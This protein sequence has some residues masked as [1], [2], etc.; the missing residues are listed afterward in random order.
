MPWRANTNK[1]VNY[2]SHK[3]AAHRPQAGPKT[4]SLR[5]RPTPSAPDPSFG[6]IGTVRTRTTRR[7]VRPTSHTL[8]DLSLAQ[9]AHE[10]RI[11]AGESIES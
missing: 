4:A 3:P 10:S 7:P 1:Y 5:R 6:P 9:P 2:D 11:L 8:Y